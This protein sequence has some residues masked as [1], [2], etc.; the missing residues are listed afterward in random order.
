MMLGYLSK[1]V[2]QML[3]TISATVIGAYIV[4]TWINPKTQPDPAK[5][6][7]QQAAKAAP[8]AEELA[9]PD[10]PVAPAP[11]VTKSA[12]AAETTKPV[13][14]S[15]P[16][17]EAAKAASAPDNVRVIPIVKQP[18]A[19]AE[20]SVTTAAQAA[21]AETV[22]AAEERKD[23]NELA[24]AAIQR[25]RRGSESARVT[26]EP[27]VKPAILAVRVQQPR[28]AP[29]PLQASSLATVAPPLPPAVSI[30]S[31]RYSQFEVSDQGAPER[32]TPPGEIPTMRQPLGLQASHRVGENAS[33]AEDF[34]SA[35]KSF[36]RAITPQ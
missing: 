3:P 19:T 5:I 30:A 17:K 31:P 25:L 10:I 16:A 32:P 18:A 7:A 1:F 8:A 28:V 26:D 4:T 36:F 27:A 2:L 35:T 9:V 14:T 21:A 23:A 34:V 15:Q 22:A 13:E 12:E 11:A 29:E 6:A 20:L 24:R 33:F